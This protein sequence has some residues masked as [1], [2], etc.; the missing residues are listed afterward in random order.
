MSKLNT[1]M[2]STRQQHEQIV[3]VF[4]LLGSFSSLRTSACIIRVR[5][6]FKT[7]SEGTYVAS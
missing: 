6:H 1:V 4:E 3:H 5:Q 7:R 2:A